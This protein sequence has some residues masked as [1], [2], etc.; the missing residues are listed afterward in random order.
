MSDLFEDSAPEGE[1]SSARSPLEAASL[2]APLAERM[3]PR[4]LDDLI[5]Q[6]EVVGPDTPLR[7]MVEGDQLRSIIFWGPPGSGKTTLATI[8]AART[9]SRFIPLSAVTSSIKDAKALMEEARRARARFGQRTILFV[10]EIHRFN[11]AQQDAFLPFVEEGSIVLIGATTENPSFSL[12]SAL[13]SRCAVFV[14]KPLEEEEIVRILEKAVHDPDRGL[15]RLEPLI[16]EGVLPRIAAIADGDARR[17]LNLLEM[18]VQSAPRVDE[19]RPFVDQESLGQVLRRQT[20]LYDKTGEE[21]YNL[22]SAFHKSMRGSDAQAALYWAQRMLQSG[23]DPLYL[24]RRMIRFASEDIGNAD[25]QALSL[26]IAARQAYEV[27]GSPE[28]ELALLQCAV[29]LATAPKSNAVYVASKLARAEIERSGSLPVPLHIRNAPTSLMKD[30]GY[31]AGYQY[32]HDQE[33]GVSAQE[34]LPEGL[35]QRL[36]YQPAPYGFEREIAKRMEWWDRKRAEKRSPQKEEKARSG[37]K[38]RS[39]RGNA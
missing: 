33:G 22:I 9:Q 21:H 18:A 28:G 31:G 10:D 11:R 39:D 24:A 19:V 36:F 5:G 14:L 17:A 29:Y 4:T 34:F 27:L 15:G 32:D 6:E 1:P 3:R 7:R 30:L 25:P 16:Q 20:L 38:D 26:A 37:P 35:T 8:I 13:L 2:D 23:E 12:V